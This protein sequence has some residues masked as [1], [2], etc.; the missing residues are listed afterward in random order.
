MTKTKWHTDP[1]E[2]ENRPVWVTCSDLEVKW[3]ASTNVVDYMNMA[4]AWTEYTHEKPE[5]YEPPS[6]ATAEE[7]EALREL[8]GWIRSLISPSCSPQGI[9]IKILDKLDAARGIE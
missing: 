5:P 2:G 4:I 1:P 8:E 3:C 6:E 9:V 7:I